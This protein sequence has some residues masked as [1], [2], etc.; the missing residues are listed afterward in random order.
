M[1]EKVKKLLESEDMGDV[2]IGISLLTEN[3]THKVM[4]CKMNCKYEGSIRFFSLGEHRF[5]LNRSMRQYRRSRYSHL[6][7]TEITR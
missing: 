4:D 3:D 2:I 7:G 6:N 1:T 5:Y